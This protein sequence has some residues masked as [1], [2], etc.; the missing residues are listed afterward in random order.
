MSAHV[1]FF[2]ASCYL[3]VLE[4]FGNGKIRLSILTPSQC[5]CLNNTAVSQHPV[6]SVGLRACSGGPLLSAREHTSAV[7]EFTPPRCEFLL[8]WSSLYRALCLLVVPMVLTI[9]EH[10]VSPFSSPKCYILMM[11]S[12]CSSLSRNNLTGRGN[13]GQISKKQGNVSRGGL[14]FLHFNVLAAII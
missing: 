2:N 7:P 6:H 1:N 11:K 5:A 8:H 13:T 14:S 12:K 4:T 9:T 3:K 10:S